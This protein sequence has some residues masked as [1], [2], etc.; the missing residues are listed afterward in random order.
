MRLQDAE[1]KAAPRRPFELDDI[2]MRVAAIE[3]RQQARAE[4]DYQELKQA[5]E[6]K[7]VSS[8]QPLL[9]FRSPASF[10]ESK[11]LPNGGGPH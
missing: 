9:L 2:E 11:G 4:R 1:L 8:E 10:N 6:L 5:C 7:V 3:A